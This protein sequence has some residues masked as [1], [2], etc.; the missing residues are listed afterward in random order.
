LAPLYTQNDHFTKTGSEQTWGKLKAEWCFLTADAAE[1]VDQFR[2]RVSCLD[3]Q[4][5][6][7]PIVRLHGPDAKQIEQRASGTPENISLVSEF[8]FP[9]LC[10]RSPFC[11]ID[12]V[13]GCAGCHAVLK[14]EMRKLRHEDVHLL[15]EAGAAPTW[16]GVIWRR[17]ALGESVF[18]D[19]DA[20]WQEY[21]CVLTV[22]RQ[23]AFDAPF[24]ARKQKYEQLPRQARERS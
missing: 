6:W 12:R 2:F 14:Q 22:R 10:R 24:S 9:E 16:S 18:K 21:H 7:P 5:A 23:H 3:R 19:S 17:A 8:L 13:V 15:A 1:S 4:H 11:W 20:R